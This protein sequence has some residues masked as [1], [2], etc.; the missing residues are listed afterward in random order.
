ME[1]T[2]SQWKPLNDEMGDASVIDQ[3]FRIWHAQRATA[4]LT[5]EICSVQVLNNMR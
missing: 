1:D 5:K 2:A 4:P 3:G